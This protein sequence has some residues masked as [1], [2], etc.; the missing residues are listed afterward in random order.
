MLQ[1][2]L[3]Q[4]LNS[5]M[6]PLPFLLINT[7]SFIIT[8][9]INY[10]GGSGDYFGKSVGDI[11][12]DFTTLITPAAYAFSIWGLIYLSLISFLVYQWVC[13]FKK[14]NNTSL[15]PSGLWFTVANLSNAL[16]IYVWVNEQILLSVIVILVLLFSLIQLVLRLRL[17]IYD[18]P[19]KTIFL[20][21]WP[22]CIYTGWVIL[23]TVLTLSVGIKS[24][25][26]LDGLWSETAWA[27][28]ILIIATSIY[29]FLTYN[30]NMREA[31]L[32][33]AWGITAIAVKQWGINETLSIIAIAL[34]GILV[35]IAGIHSY[36]NRETS[37]P[38]KMG[39]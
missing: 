12:D 11:S 19:I 7:I 35:L 25:G 18:A 30:R 23:A 34:A 16:W 27:S 13:Y 20:V 1:L 17:E 5:K 39:K 6:K 4:N 8:L 31:A 26:I 9:F 15:E 22:I 29:A 2:T 38:A 33:G 32:V 21:W 3:Q 37:I 24:T 10:L 14:Q 28:L 36:I